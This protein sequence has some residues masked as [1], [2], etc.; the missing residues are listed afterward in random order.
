MIETEK[1]KE[2]YTGFDGKGWL[3]SEC[4]EV[5]KK[6]ED[7]WVEWLNTPIDDP[8]HDYRGSGLRLVHHLPAS[9]RKLKRE[10]GCQ[11]NGNVEFQ[12]NR[13]LV[14]DNSLSD[15]VGADGLMQLL[16]MLAENKM[17][18]KE[19]LELTK[20]IHIPGYERAHLH[21]NEAISEGVYEPNTV[22]GY[23]FQYQI[24]AINNWLA[25]QE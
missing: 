5:I 25:E 14:S 19:V 2:N 9:P 13:S 11:Y 10:M 7:G 24:R 3:C 18:R 8:E 15:F 21:F 1:E 16:A 23:P 12:K 17:S 20:R 6:A 22:V 4:G